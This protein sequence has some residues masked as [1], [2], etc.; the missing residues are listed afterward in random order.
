MTAVSFVRTECCLLGA[1]QDTP[2]D[3]RGP[4]DGA[5]QR[6][7]HCSWPAGT[8]P[9]PALPL[10]P[11]PLLPARP[12]LGQARLA[13]SQSTPPA[14]SS[15]NCRR[16]APLET[17]LVSQPHPVNAISCGLFYFRL[18]SVVAVGSPLAIVCTVLIAATVITRGSRVRWRGEGG[19][20]VYTEWSNKKAKPHGAYFMAVT[21]LCNIIILRIQKFSV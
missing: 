21:N 18:V 8:S 10:G 2:G 17:K 1:R 20:A 3:N 15:S 13:P 9:W 12:E 6:V 4:D 14:R 11:A 16:S 19:A 5:I 7:P